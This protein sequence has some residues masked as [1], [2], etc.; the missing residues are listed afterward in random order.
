MK[1]IGYG[2]HANPRETCLLCETPEGAYVKVIKEAE[3]AV[4]FLT[5]DATEIEELGKALQN[6]EKLVEIL[7]LE[8]E[9]LQ[10]LE[11][12]FVKYWGKTEKR[13]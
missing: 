3:G 1:C 13:R 10:K 5:P 9:N 8:K 2:K 4:R 12:A 6:R 11:Q 7:T